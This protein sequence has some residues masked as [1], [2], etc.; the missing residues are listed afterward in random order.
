MQVQKAK[1]VLIVAGGTGGHIFPAL[2]VAKQ[3]RQ[4]GMNIHWLG[5]RIGMESKLVPAEFPISY[6]SIDKL[7]GNRWTAKLLAPIRISIAL[8]QSLWIIWRFKPNLVLGM[9]GFASGPAGLAAWI[10]RKPLIIHEQNSVAGLTNRI[11]A[12]FA[13]KILCAFPNAFAKDVDV[14]VVGNPVREEICEISAPEFRLQNRTGDLRLLVLG[15]SQGARAINFLVLQTL[16]HFNQ[17]NQL[18]VWHQCGSLDFDEVQERYSQL[19]VKAKVTAFIDDVAA[20]YAWA[21][22]VICRAGAL[23]V[24]ELAAVGLASILVPYPYCK[25]DHQFFNANYLVEQNAAYIFR[26]K[27]FSMQRLSDTLHLLLNQRDKLEQMSYQA[28]KLARPKA[29]QYVA[30]ICCEQLQGRLHDLSES[31]N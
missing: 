9:G 27:E 10:L 5:T 26:Q 16:Q 18:D 24:S 28:R 13:R 21:D 19:P 22:L 23:T 20:A 17:F 8:C 6:I 11:L 31:Q 4:R 30:D 12:K 15:G 3:L 7:R 2:A 1:R 25:D 14:E 29:A